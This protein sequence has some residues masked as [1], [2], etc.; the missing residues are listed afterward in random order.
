MRGVSFL[1]RPPFC[2]IISILA[3]FEFEIYSLN[4]FFVSAKASSSLLITALMLS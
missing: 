2:R 1:R 3:P 4:S